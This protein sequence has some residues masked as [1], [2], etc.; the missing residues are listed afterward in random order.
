MFRYVTWVSECPQMEAIGE[1]PLRVASPG[2]FPMEAIGESPLRVA[3]PGEFPGGDS[4][5][6][7]VM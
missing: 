7:G 1:S 2:E 5:R 3:S 6:S 4:S